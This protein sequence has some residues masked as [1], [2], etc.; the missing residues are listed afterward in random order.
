MA[1]T[2]KY[3]FFRKKNSKKFAGKEKTPNFALALRHE[4]SRT[5]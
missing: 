4:Q 1:K 3:H 5:L 2:K